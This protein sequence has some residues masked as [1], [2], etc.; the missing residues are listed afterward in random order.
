MGPGAKVRM[1]RQPLRKVK[2]YAHFRGFCYFK[3]IA[4]FFPKY[5]CLLLTL[6]QGCSKCTTKFSSQLLGR[7][8]SSSF[9]TTFF[10][11]LFPIYRN[12]AHIV[13]GG[14]Q[15][16]KRLHDDAKLRRRCEVTR[17]YARTSLIYSVVHTPHGPRRG[18]SEARNLRASYDTQT[19]SACR[20]ARALSR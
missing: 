3:V 20:H 2:C 18:S 13:V 9:S 8:F 16:V 14:P 19:S 10:R 7:T 6:Q 4:K 12:T 5:N 17:R 15:F 1:G 11:I